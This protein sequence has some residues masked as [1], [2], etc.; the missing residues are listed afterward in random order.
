M[1]I[2]IAGGRGKIAPILGRLLRE[3]GDSVAGFIRNPAHAADLEA[4]GAQTLG[5]D[6]EEELVRE[7]PAHR[8]GADRVVCSVGAAPPRAAVVEVLL[9][10]LA[11]PETVG[12]TFEVISGD[13][14]ITEAVTTSSRE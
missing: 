3:R 10:V 5:P 8:R 11:S 9:A 4:A 14:P 1:R 6:L 12:Q 2:V 7:I 13:T